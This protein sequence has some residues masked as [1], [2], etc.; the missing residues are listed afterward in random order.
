MM[1]LRAVSVVFAIGFATAFI[2]PTVPVAAAPV[3]AA[4]PGYV[5]VNGAGGAFTFGSARYEGSLPGSGIV[6]NNVVDVQ[7]LKNGR[8]Y[9][10]VTST[11]HVYP[12]G[13]ARSYGS[14]HPI[15]PVV[16][17][18]A[19]PDDLGYWVVDLEGNI[20]GFGDARSYGSLPGSGIL[21]H[22]IVAIAATADGKGYYVAGA[23]GLV[24]SYGDTSFNGPFKAPFGSAATSIALDSVTGGFWLVSAR[25]G[26][27]AFHAHYYG[28]SP[29]LS[30]VV[31]IAPSPDSAG[32]WLVN[33]QGMVFGHG[34]AALRGSVTNSGT[35]IVAIGSD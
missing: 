34:D 25:G 32:Y 14:A 7:V 15:A 19:T 5:V 9:W 27:Y 20:Q 30:P 23:N 28:A 16:G 18:A 4:N 6:A 2:V 21:V 26:I 12:F 24:Y 33:N 29:S 22:D 10:M 3:T 1:K 17:I 11:G 13:A 31:G 8:G 35:P